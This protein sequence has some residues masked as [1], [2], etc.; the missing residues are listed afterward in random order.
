MEKLKIKED[1]NLKIGGYL[2]QNLIK[3]Q[4]KNI[5]EEAI[6]S[7]RKSGVFLEIEGNIFVIKSMSEYKKVIDEL[8]MCYRY[9]LK[10][11]PKE[12]D[13]EIMNQA[14]D[15]YNRTDR[16]NILIKNKKCNISNISCFKL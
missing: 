7:I 6:I 12:S 15:I 9:L 4:K 3:L 16:V 10:Y 8:S 2:V 14:F 13:N 11:I 5:G 1:C